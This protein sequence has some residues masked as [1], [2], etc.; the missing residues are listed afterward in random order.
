MVLG[1]KYLQSFSP[2]LARGSATRDTPISAACAGELEVFLDAAA[3]HDG[4][5]E[6]G[7][8]RPARMLMGML[9]G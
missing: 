6:I 3:A 2:C 5:G 7:A 8:V 1:H 4:G 9:Q